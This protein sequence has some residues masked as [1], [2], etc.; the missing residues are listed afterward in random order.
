MYIP[1]LFLSFIGW[2]ILV[3]LGKWEEWGRVSFVSSV[4]LS[5]YLLVSLSLSLSLLPY[6]QPLSSLFLSLTSS[7]SVSPDRWSA[8]PHGGLESEQIMLCTPSSLLSVSFIFLPHQTSPS[9]IL[10]STPCSLSLVTFINHR[11]CL[12]LSPFSLPLPL[13]IYFALCY[14]PLSHCG[15]HLYL[16]FLR[17]PPPHLCLLTNK[18]LSFYRIAI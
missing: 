8:N 9:Y 7:P 4:S 2:C 18:L 6:P 14:I 5:V 16:L 3:I 1:H 15:S 17:I 10:P 13:Y 11:P 12:P